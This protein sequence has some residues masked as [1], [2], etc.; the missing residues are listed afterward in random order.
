MGYKG[1]RLVAALC[2]LAV[3]LGMCAAQALAQA[4]PAD[5]RA[6]EGIFGALGSAQWESMLPVPVPASFAPNL[7]FD[8]YTGP[9]E[10]YLREANGRA[11][12]ST[13]DWVLVFGEEDGYLMVAYRVSEEQLRFGFIKATQEEAGVSVPQ[14][15]WADE[16]IVFYASLVSDP[17]EFDSGDER[18]STEGTG[19][20]LALFGT[21]WAYVESVADSGKSVRGFASI[22]DFAFDSDELELAI[23]NPAEGDSAALYDAPGGRQTGKLY[24]GVIVAVK[25]EQ[26]G[27]LRVIHYD[28]Q[29]EDLSLDL[30]VQGWVDARDVA[31][32][33]DELQALEDAPPH[34][35]WMMPQE[36]EA[37]LAQSGVH[38]YRLRAEVE[39]TA[40]L[41]TLTDA[42]GARADSSL[43][44]EPTRGMLYL[45]Q[46]R[47]ER[48]ELAQ[49]DAY[50]GWYQGADAAAS[51]EADAERFLPGT[52]V[53]VLTHVRGMAL[54]CAIT[55]YGTEGPYWVDARKVVEI[56]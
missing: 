5:E 27:L 37:A 25:E 15:A 23:V 11:S 39:G 46:S 20:L 2:L 26:G 14:L 41:Q 29:D 38:A 43:L 19:T 9:G 36:G 32:G 6:S 49:V 55:E 16:P 45:P 42:L 47:D 18:I 8:V 51:G 31:R 53:Y 34:V 7:R 12:V 40:Y 10:N 30:S 28:W 21:D 54:V 50:M 35:V 48:G 1:A 17:V 22:V 13:N 33:M 44:L 24:P 56:L 3:L 4:R 52:Q